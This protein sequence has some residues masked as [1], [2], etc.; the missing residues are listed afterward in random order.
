[1]TSFAKELM[2]Y[3]STIIWIN[4]NKLIFPISIH[5]VFAREK[6]PILPEDSISINYRGFSDENISN[7]KNPIQDINWNLVLIND[8]ADEAYDLSQITLLTVKGS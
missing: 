2:R 8:D 5:A 7:F 3:Y 6:F 4:N 1:M